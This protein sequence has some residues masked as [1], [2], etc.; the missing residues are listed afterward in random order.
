MMYRLL[1][2]RNVPSKA[3]LV[4]HHTI[5]RPILLYEHESWVKTK[6]LDSRIRAA[7]MKV[8]QLITYVTRRD[9]IRNADISDAFQIKPILEVIREESSD[10]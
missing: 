6:R 5:L 2:D 7:I 10:G 9:Q 1:K 4:I 3:K 8:L